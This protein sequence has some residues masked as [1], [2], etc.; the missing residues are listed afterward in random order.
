MSNKKKNKNNFLLD[1]NSIQE[2]SLP[3]EN[4]SKENVPKENV[5]TEKKKYATRKIS[6]KLQ[7][8][9]INSTTQKFNNNLLNENENVITS[10]D[11]LAN[12]N[13][14]CNENKNSEIKVKRKKK[15]VLENKITSDNSKIKYDTNIFD[16]QIIEI[17]EC[18]NVDKKVYTIDNEIEKEFVKIL[19]NHHLIFTENFLFNNH[20]LWYG[21]S[22]SNK[23]NLS[24]YFIN[25]YFGENHIKLEKHIFQISNH[26]DT[27][28]IV[29]YKSNYHWEIDFCWTGNN[30]NNCTNKNSN[31]QY[32]I[33]YFVNHFCK[34]CNININA[35]KILVF[36][37]THRLTYNNQKM[38]LRIMESTFENVKFIITTDYINKIDLTIKSRCINVRIPAIF[39]DYYYFVSINC[40][41]NRFNFY[42]SKKITNMDE[43]LEFYIDSELQKILKNEKWTG[44]S[45]KKYL[46][47]LFNEIIDLKKNIECPQFQ[48]KY[49]SIIDKIDNYL[50]AC[51]TIQDF[52]QKFIKYLSNVN[53]MHIKNKLYLYVSKFAYLEYTSQKCD[54]QLYIIESSLSYFLLN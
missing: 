54:Y 8:I 27:L 20:L 36:H 50:L 42:K 18:Q 24:R 32:I 49:Y 53:D 12:N 45:E 2:N 7:T 6:H 17:S 33:D 41:T 39:N 51:N 40:I 23:K 14:L 52:F 38:I 29:I 28:Q 9:E 26:H 25:R 22:E 15:L 4:V 30:T 21:P 16:P 48:S 46:N 34:T 35:F 3:T 47:L 31:D 5:S 43:P 10:N 37:N 1:E 11:I 19:E 13:N 44:N